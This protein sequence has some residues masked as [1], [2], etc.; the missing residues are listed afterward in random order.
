MYEVM[1]F[2][3]YFGIIIGKSMVKLVKFKNLWVLILLQILN[4]ALLST[5]CYISFI[6]Y[7]A[8]FFISFWVGIL[9]G[10]CYSNVFNCLLKSNEISKYFKEAASNLV[11]IMANF[12][13]ILASMATI[14][15][16]KYLISFE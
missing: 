13:I 2:C 15:I 3:Y 9:G 12:G 1:Q 4:V 7:W 10:L 14:L 11:L 8:E 5:E 16:D 6:P